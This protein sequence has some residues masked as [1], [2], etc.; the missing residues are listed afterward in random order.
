MPAPPRIERKRCPNPVCSST[1]DGISP[2]FRLETRVML[3]IDNKESDRWVAYICGYCGT[4]L[5]RG[6]LNE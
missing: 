1:K 3:E 4:E 2:Y 5:P 6:S